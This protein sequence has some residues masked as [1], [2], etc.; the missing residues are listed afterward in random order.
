MYT[1]YLLA[2]MKI[3]TNAWKKYI[4]QL[5]LIQFFLITLH[6]LQLAWVK[7]CGFPLWPAYVMV[8]QNLFMMILFGDFYYKTYVKK[9]ATTKITKTE[10]NGISEIANGKPKEQ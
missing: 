4:T 6:Y 8:P 9:Q 10:I 2:S 3:N 1:H 5:Q 7:D